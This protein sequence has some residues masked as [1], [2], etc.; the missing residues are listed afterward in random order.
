MVYLI[1]EE[2]I[3][4]RYSERNPI[5]YIRCKNQE[6]ANKWCEEHSMPIE[7]FFTKGEIRGKL[8]ATLILDIDANYDSWKAVI[9]RDIEEENSAEEEYYDLMM[10]K[11][12]QQLEEEELMLENYE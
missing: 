9:V 3:F 10:R 6:E 1:S 2:R 8:I 5:G 7:L 11:E 4:S 12:K